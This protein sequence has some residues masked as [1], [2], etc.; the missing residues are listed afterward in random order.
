MPSSQSSSVD[1]EEMRPGGAI[2]GLMHVESTILE[3]RGEGARRLRHFVRVTLAIL[4]PV[5]HGDGQGGGGTRIEV[6]GHA[7]IGNFVNSPS[8]RLVVGEHQTRR[9]TAKT[10]VG[11]HGADV[12]AVVERHRPDPAGKHP[13]RMC[14]VEQHLGPNLISDFANFGH[15]MGKQI[16][17]RADRDE[18]RADLSRQ[19]GQAIQIVRVAL[20]VDRTLVNLEAVEAGRAVPVVCDMAPNGGRGNDD[21]IAG[22]ASGHERVE[23]RHGARS[24]S[25]FSELASKH[26][27]HQ[28]GRDDF[29]FLHCLE[30][31]LVFLAGVTK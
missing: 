15:G 19:F 5:E 2:D 4:K 1:G 7:G 30:T 11:A 16:E 24:D 12:G 6:G 18:L 27:P 3:R 25:Q 21:G 10:L 14:R 28:R 31:H 26:S 13:A 23:V 29:D 9:R 20:R 22:R 8:Q 17:T